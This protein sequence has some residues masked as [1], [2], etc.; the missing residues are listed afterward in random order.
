MTL[1]AYIVDDLEV[2]RYTA[3]RRLTKTGKFTDIHEVEDGRQ[4]LRYLEETE[5][6]PMGRDEK[7]LVLMDINMPIMN[8]FETVEALR[9]RLAGSAWLDHL[10]VVIVSSSDAPQDR[11]RAA[12][13]TFVQG[14]LVKPIKLSDMEAIISLL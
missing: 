14:Y 11:T 10:A 9:E 2:D 7:I 5:P 3:R 8:G 1:T 6:P 13:C 4:F 12:D